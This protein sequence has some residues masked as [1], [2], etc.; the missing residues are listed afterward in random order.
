MPSS[1]YPGQFG[2][3]RVVESFKRLAGPAGQWL[4]RATAFLLAVW[5][6]HALLRVALLFRKDAFGFDIVGKADWYIFHALFIDLHW[7]FLWSLPLLFLMVVTARFMPRW[8][9]IFFKL[10]IVF[11]SVLLLLTVIDHE[12]LRFMGAH[13]DLGFARVYGNSAS[14]RQVFHF[15]EADKSI[16]YLPYVLFFGCIPVSLLLYRQ[17]TQAAWVRATEWR[18]KPVA[19]ILGG[20]LVGYLYVYQIWTGYHRMARLRPFV[21]SVY[22]SLERKNVPSLSAD[23]LTLLE[24]RYQMLWRIGSGDGNW[25]FPRAD[26]P[27]YRV[28]LE[29][30]CA[31][32][33]KPMLCDAD[34][35]GDGYP[36]SHDCL[37][38]DATVHP[39]AIDISGNGVD[40]DCDGIDAKPWNF[41]FLLLESHR[42]VNVG[43]LKPYGAFDSATPFLDSLAHAG[44][45]WTRMITSGLPTIHA[46][47]AVHLSILQHPMRYISSEFT[48]LNHRSFTA[49]LGRYGYRTHY[50]SAPDPAWD[51]QTPWLRQW[52]QGVTYH[53]DQENDGDMLRNMSAWMRDSLSMD[54]PF[55]V[56]GMTKSNHY[57]FDA[58][59]D[60]NAE[61][62]GLPINQRIHFTM[63]YTDSCIRVFVNSLRDQPWFDH[64]VFIVMADHGF[65][66]G[67]HGCSNIGCGLYNENVWLPF[68]VAGAHTKLGSPGPHEGL[69]AHFDLGP[70]ILDL[71]GIREENS[72]MGH[73]LLLP[74]KRENQTGFLFRAEQALIERG[75]Y[76]WHGAWGN[77]QRE[78]GE[79][80]FDVETDRME[81]HNILSEHRSLRD[82]LEPLA[83]QLARLHLHVIE[84]NRLWPDSL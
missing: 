15:L 76:R 41:V 13:F 61:Q 68:V 62:R 42:G 71:A 39:G 7:I 83:R 30:Y 38:T 10:L 65:P 16:R 75:P 22:L 8:T 53:R 79:E 26:Y 25:I 50:F 63:A 6:T 24:N 29:A 59:P 9:G 73:S 40:E 60:M 58:A 48:G 45:Y 72:Y 52:Y 74:A 36:K 54:R 21:Q 69:A 28:P 37:D 1:Q 77:V 46:L 34:R 19:W 31:Q 64:T 18:L 23:S 57:P 33:V 4:N 27:Y 5:M 44:H 43:H 14:V 17:L 47:I 12:T 70:T 35:D 51:N 80:L 82:S 20:S 66:L 32:V 2:L 67:E 81:R 11:H 84:N 49:V 56:T 3:K 55:F 78:Q